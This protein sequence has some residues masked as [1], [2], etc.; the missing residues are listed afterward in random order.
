MTKNIRQILTA[1]I[2]VLML[3]V[4]ASTLVYFNVI[5][6]IPVDNFEEDDGNDTPPTTNPGDVVLPPSGNK[7]GNLFFTL[8]K[9]SKIL[10][11]IIKSS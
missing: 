10:K 1:V 9:I 8:S 11:S 2:V 3:A 5:D 7:V 4:L 6:K